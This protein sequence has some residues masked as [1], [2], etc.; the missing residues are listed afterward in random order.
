M[1]AFMA[2]TMS[3]TLLDMS[4]TVRNKHINLNSTDMS[5]VWHKKNKSISHPKTQRRVGRSTTETVQSRP[6]H[7]CTFRG[8]R[9]VGLYYGEHRPSDRGRVCTVRGVVQEK[10]APL[11]LSCNGQVVVSQSLPSHRLWS[12]PAP[13]G[14]GCVHG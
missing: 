11:H 9:V 6:I 12:V 4:R 8:S 10:Q 13:C 14:C 1:C 3:R 5:V 7:A 2:F